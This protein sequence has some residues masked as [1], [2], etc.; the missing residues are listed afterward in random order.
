MSHK[1]AVYWR[2]EGQLETVFTQVNKT[3]KQD[4]S[5]RLFYHFNRKLLRKTTFLKFKKK[6]RITSRK[7]I[8]TMNVY[9]H[10]FAVLMINCVSIRI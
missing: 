8:K 5:K 7:L 3:L 2:Q 9:T 10:F 1:R 4:I 6:R